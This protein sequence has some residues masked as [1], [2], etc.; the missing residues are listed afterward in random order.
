MKA[1]GIDIGTTGISGVLLDGESGALLRAI[2]KNSNAFLE[3]AAFYERIQSVDKILSVADGI[4]EELLEDGVGV[5]GV[6]GQMHGIVYLDEKGSALSPLYTWQDG[7]GDLPYK[8][9]TYAAYLGCATGYGNVTDFYNRENG[10]RPASAVTYATIHDY[11]VM[12]LCGLCEPLLHDSD[13]ASFGLYNAQTKS[14]DY[15][16]HPQVV[17]G[18]CLAGKHK[19]IPVTVA[20]GDNQASVLSTAKEGDIL[21]NVGTGSQVSLISSIPANAEGIESR[22]FFEGKHL[23]VGSALCG[24]RAYSVLKDFYKAVASCFK[25]NVS[26]GEVYAAMDKM[27]AE[28]PASPLRVDTRFAGTRTDPSV[29]GSIENVSTE[30]LTPSA[31]AHGVLCG[32]ASELYGLYEKMGV[33]ATSLVGSGNGI[34]KNAPLVALCEEMFGAKMKTPVHLEEAAFG[35]ALYALVSAGVYPTLEEAQR[36]I[37]Y[38]E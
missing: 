19:G 33:R 35:A 10:I 38:Q 34:R 21:V 1:I 6:T 24:G 4:L 11:Y 29:R 31:L 20:I 7:R 9:T 15:D 17:N 22:P 13:A 27:I 8:D 16:Y 14:F 37:R 12:H 5:I 3:S 32:M 2:T 23:L 18:F 26:D 25:E 36:L 28:K 30:N